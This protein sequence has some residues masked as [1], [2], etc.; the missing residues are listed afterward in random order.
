MGIRVDPKSTWFIDN[1][2]CRCNENK[3]WFGRVNI[4]NL[5]SPIIEMR[6]ALTSS[7]YD[8]LLKFYCAGRALRLHKF[9]ITNRAKG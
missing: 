9:G 4:M 2:L 8:R 6:V 7:D 5:P 1:G 3:K